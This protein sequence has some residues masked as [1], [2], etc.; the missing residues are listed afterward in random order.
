[1]E[2]VLVKPVYFDFES[3]FVD[4]L[5][6]IP[7]IVRYKLDTVRVKLQLAEWARLS[8]TDKETLAALPC[9]S[10]ADIARYRRYLLETV[11]E[12][13]HKV[14]KDLQVLHASW[15]N[16]HEVPA[17]VQQKAHEWACPPLRAADWARLSLLQRFALVKLSRSGH[18]GENFPRALAEFG[19]R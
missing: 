13:S 2:Q 1:M 11:W 9:E 8:D 18:E 4:T 12:R 19:V 15:E 5:R 3:D 10:E 16:R 7:M 14:P 17:E 6:C